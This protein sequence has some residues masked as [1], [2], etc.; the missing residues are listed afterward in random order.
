MPSKCQPVDFCF[1]QDRVAEREFTLLHGT[2]KN[3]KV[4]T[5][6][7]FKKLDLKQ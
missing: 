6:A 3:S 2:T 4:Y 7:D 5:T 1:G